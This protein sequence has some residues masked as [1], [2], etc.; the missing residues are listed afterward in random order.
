MSFELVTKDLGSLSVEPRNLDYKTACLE[1]NLDDVVLS[2]SASTVKNTDMRYALA[3][4]NLDVVKL[5][6]DEKPKDMNLTMKL[7]ASSSSQDVIDYLLSNGG[8]VNQA[9]KGAVMKGDKELVEYL[10]REKGANDFNLAYSV[11]RTWKNEDLM[12]FFVDKGADPNRDD[13][14]I[15]YC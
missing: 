1:G 2:L 3:S 11:A 13:K 8:D 12:Q 5:V 9:L 14:N 10:I 7:A 6:L 15:A 4:G